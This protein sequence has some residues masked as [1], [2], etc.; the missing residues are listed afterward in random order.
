LPAGAFFVRLECAFHTLP[1]GAGAK[2]NAMNRN[3][4]MLV[5]AV[6]AVATAVLGYQLY[7]ERHQKSGLDITIGDRSISIGKK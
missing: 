4:I 1:A 7:E 2:L 5:I 6:L 3:V